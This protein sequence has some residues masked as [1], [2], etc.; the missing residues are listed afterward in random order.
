LETDCCE[1]LDPEGRDSEGREP[2]G[3]EPEGRNFEAGDPRLRDSSPLGKVGMIDSD[4]SL[5]V[6]KSEK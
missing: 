3:R 4:S 5:V 6:K 1:A 2:E